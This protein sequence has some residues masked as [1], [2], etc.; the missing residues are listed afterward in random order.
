M[1]DKDHLVDMTGSCDP[2]V[3]RPDM[4]PVEDNE[5][6]AANDLVAPFL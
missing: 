2:V 1:A 6:F 3:G 4:V 5:H